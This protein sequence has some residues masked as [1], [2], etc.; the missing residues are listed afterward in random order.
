MIAAFLTVALAL[1]FT[2][3]IIIQIVT[4]HEVEDINDTY[5]GIAGDVSQT[6]KGG[7][8]PGATGVDLLPLRTCIRCSSTC[9]VTDPP[10]V[11]YLPSWCDPTGST[12]YARKMRYA[13]TDLYNVP[14]E[15][16]HKEMV[17]CC[18]ILNLMD[19]CLSRT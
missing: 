18:L 16:V 12:A 8:P 4:G 5:V 7:G 15:R 3:A 11:R 1:R 9:R 2:T 13:V 19:G 6:M 14:Y 17:S 10:K